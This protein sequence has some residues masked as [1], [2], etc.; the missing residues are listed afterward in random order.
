MFQGHYVIL[1]NDFTDTGALQFFGTSIECLAV[2]NRG[3]RMQGIRALGIWYEGYQPSWFCQYLGN[4]IL[5]GNY[6]HFD[7]ATDAVLEVGSSTQPPYTGTMNR[8]AIVRGNHLHNH[9][10]IRVAGQCRNVVVER[11]RVE[12]VDQGIFISRE[13]RDVLSANNTFRGV[14]QPVVDEETARKI[15]EERMKRYLGLRDPAAAWTFDAIQDGSF[16]DGSGHGFFAAVEDGVGVADGVRGHAAR[17][18]GKGYL[19]V[20]E[21]AVFNAPDI[22]VSLWIKPPAVSGR[23]GLVVKRFAGS[24]TPLVITQQGACIGFEASDADGHWPFKLWLSGGPQGEPMDPRG[25]HHP[26][27]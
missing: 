23:R 18:D 17:F 27:R 3:T 13:A 19:R 16:A 10:Q 14:N 1:D 20:E 22:T 6:Y 4:A 5:E 26:P 15:A 2:G 21:S 25:R 9:A 24:G 12:N 11:N 8:G 7:S